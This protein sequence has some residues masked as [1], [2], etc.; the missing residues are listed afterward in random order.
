MLVLMLFTLTLLDPTSISGIQLPPHMCGLLHRVWPEAIPISNIPEVV[1]QA[2]I[3]GWITWFGVSS[4]IVTDRGRQFE[5]HL[6]NN[7]M[8]LLGT[9]RSDP[10]PQANGMVK[11][12]HCQ[13]KAAL[14]AQPNPDTW[15]TSL[16]LILLGIRTSFKQDLFATTAEMVYGSTLHLPG[17]FF[18]PAPAT[19]LPDPS[20]FLTTL[21]THLQ[22][23]Q[24]STS[25]M[26][27]MSL[28]IM[29]QRANPSNLPTMDHI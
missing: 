1:V 22:N 11:H 16:P 17:K 21:R 14:N 19:S 13:L 5:L 7:L 25:L 15:M 9:K 20:A 2:F 26:Q 28:S 12:F 3:N 18:T 29:M 27:H 24:H 23:N 10:H 6:W 4:T 8:A